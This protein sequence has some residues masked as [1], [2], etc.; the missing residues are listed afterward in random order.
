VIAGA[1]AAG[2]WWTDPVSGVSAT[3]LTNRMWTSPQPPPVFDA[4]RALAFG[5]VASGG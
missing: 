4:F 2:T 3:L 5:A 1:L